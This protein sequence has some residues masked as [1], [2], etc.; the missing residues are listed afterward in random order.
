M[1]GGTYEDK[2]DEGETHTHTHKY[3]LSTQQRMSERV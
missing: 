2:K 3:F 1:E